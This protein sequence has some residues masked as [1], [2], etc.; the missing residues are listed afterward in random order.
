MKYRELGD[1]H[2][3]YSGA[4]VAPYTTVFVGGNHEASNH[5]FELYYGGWVAPNIY[6]MGA[7]N[8]LRLGPVRIAGLSGIWKGYNYRKPHYERLPYS[9]DDVR[10]AYHVREYDVRKLLQLGTQVDI[11]ISHDW[12]NG[13]EWLGEYKWLFR[14]KDLFEK[15]ARMGSLGSVAGKVV[16][17][18][19]RPPYWFSAH[20]H[21]KYAAVVD[22]TGPWPDN[23]PLSESQTQAP[24]NNNFSQ[25]YGNRSGM[26]DEGQQTAIVPVLEVPTTNQDEIDLDMDDDDDDEMPKGGK[27]LAQAESTKNAA[28]ID[29]DLDDDANEKIAVKGVPAK[30]TE[31]SS[32]PEDLRALLPA[33]F[34]KPPQPTR[35]PDPPTTITNTTTKFLSLDKCLPR[36]DFLQLL[37]VPAHDQDDETQYDTTQ[38]LPLTYDPEWLAIT[39]VFAADLPVGSVHMSIPRDLGKAHYA[40]LIATALAWVNENITEEKLTIPRNFVLTAPVHDP[41]ANIRAQVQPREY[42]NPQTEA[43]CVLLQIP[44]P[45]KLSEEEIGARMKAGPPPSEDRGGFRGGRGSAGRGGRGG[46]RGRGGR[47]R[48]RP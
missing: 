15:D 1:F 34:A 20:L 28:E 46:G 43:F 11:G 41:S 17:Q 24:S 32:I 21:I 6:Y 2:A 38:P 10:S 40:P 31:T 7:A 39:R 18:H 42:S 44:N 27:P 48:G 47:G 3:Y 29:L 33:A 8:V 35:E 45:F 26:V 36:R 22:H 16:L 30:D 37:E 9:S 25:I 5:N 14:K 13:V 4:E 19:L 23:A 12:P